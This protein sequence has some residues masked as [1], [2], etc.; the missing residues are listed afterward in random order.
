MV[1][2]HIVVLLVDPSPDP[3][4]TPLLASELEIMAISWAIFDVPAHLISCPYFG[5]ISGL[6]SN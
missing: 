4:S 5:E 3:V 1:L 6:V 2:E